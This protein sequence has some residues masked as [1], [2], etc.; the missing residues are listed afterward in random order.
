MRSKSVAFINIAF[1]LLLVLSFGSC[2]K[3]GKGKLV[4]YHFE[5]IGSSGWDPADVISFEPWPE[6]STTAKDHIYRMELIFRSSARHDIKEIPIALVTE[7]ENG[8]ITTDTVVV[9][10]EKVGKRKVRTREKFGIRESRFTLRR[11]MRLTD[12]YA[13][14]LSPL[15]EQKNTEGLLNV[16]LRLFQ[17]PSKSTKK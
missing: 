16:G 10:P 3:N 1:M 11:R 8:V 13:V 2:N 6:D 5:D 17:L 15:T 9:T 4:Y 7:N 12:G 14:S